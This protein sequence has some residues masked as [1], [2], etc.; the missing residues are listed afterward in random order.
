MDMNVVMIGNGDFVEVQGTAEKNPF[1]KAQIDKLLE[2]AKKGI[3]E[4]FEIQKKNLDGLK[5]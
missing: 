5:L 1:S 2:L 4:L 3:G